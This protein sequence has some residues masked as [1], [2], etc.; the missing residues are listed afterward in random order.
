[1]KNEELERLADTLWTERHV[2]EYLLFKLV[3]AKLLLAAD[4]RRFI[5]PAMDE[6]KCVLTTLRETEARRMEALLPVAAAWRLAAADLTIAEL[7][8]RAPE[9][10][11]TVFR[12]L[13]EAFIR[14]ADEIEETA[15]ANRRLASTGLA[16]V[17][18][19]LDALAGPSQVATNT[20]TGQHQAA[21]LSTMRLDRSL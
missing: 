2:V 16:Q 18:S 6:V 12:D 21:E 9:P 14:L 19:S 3:T 17:H 8:E 13:Q 10:M 11:A 20:A 15:A 4:D 1:M 5:T 7:A